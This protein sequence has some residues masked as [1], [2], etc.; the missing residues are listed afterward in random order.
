MRFIFYLAALLTLAACNTSATRTSQQA[1][2]R[3][4]IIVDA[5]TANEVDDLFALVRA[6]AEP[7]FDLRGITSAQFHTSPLAS[8]NT[9]Q[10][11]QDINEELLRLLDREDIPH[12][13]GA[14]VPLADRSTPSPSPAASLI[15]EEALHLPP[16]QKLH[17][18]ILGSCTNVASAVLLEPKIIPR[19]SVHYLGFWHDPATNTYNKK[20][21]NSGNDTLAVAVLLD[22]EGLEL[23]VMTATTSQHLVFD[24][25][26]VEQRLKGQGG[27]ADYLVD[28]WDSYTRWWTQE[29]PEKAHWIMWDVA[30]IEAL[31]RPE[32]ASKEGYPTPP[33]NAL[34]EIG[35]YTEIDV[36]GMKTDFW[37]R[38]PGLDDA[39]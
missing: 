35:I 9:V 18:V 12:P 27:A 8:D 26:D 30:I 32:L 29:D 31:A 25:T 11:S 7:T 16:G 39:E 20:E 10:E 34:R 17:L 33:E 2:T 13:L 6:V 1:P 3:L 19:V 28:R 23:D 24:R 37:S 14:N 36:P 38:F 5:D 22:T 4:P 21:F 15:I